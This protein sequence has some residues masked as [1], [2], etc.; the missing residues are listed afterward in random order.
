MLLAEVVFLVATDDVEWCRE[1]LADL[2]SAPDLGLDVR[3]TAE[4]SP[5]ED[6]AGEHFDWAVLANVDHLVLLMGSFGSSAGVLGRAENVFLPKF[7]P[8]GSSEVA[9]YAFILS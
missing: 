6:I 7:V 2:A 3:L 1:N 4:Y 5:R 8:G 9:L